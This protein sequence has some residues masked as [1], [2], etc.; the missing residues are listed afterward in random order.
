MVYTVGLHAELTLAVSRLVGSGCWPFSASPSSLAQPS[1]LIKSLQAKSSSLG[2]SPPQ[3]QSYS[4]TGQS[5]QPS[6]ALASHCPTSPAPYHPQTRCGGLRSRCCKKHGVTTGRAGALPAVPIQCGGHKGVV[7][8]SK[9]SEQPSLAIPG[10][11]AGSQPTARLSR[12]QQCP[13]A[14]P[15]KEG[16]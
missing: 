13:S 4:S 14:C 12:Q 11:E 5:P 7:V 10:A 9:I 6:S 8:A 15:V 1:A 2:S 16:G 3:S